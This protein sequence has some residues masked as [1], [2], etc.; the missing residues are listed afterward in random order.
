[1]YPSSG[2][3]TLKKSNRNRIEAFE[4]WCCMSVNFEI[5]SQNSVTSSSVR[6][7]VITSTTTTTTTVSFCTISLI[8]TDR[9]RSHQRP[10]KEEASGITGAT[11]FTGWMFFLSP[12]QQR[13]ITDFNDIMQKDILYRGRPTDEVCCYRLTKIFGQR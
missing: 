1:M 2:G 6:Y 8:S 11:Y 9:C 7:S 5:L 10:Y 4:M 3:W 13:Q 12:N